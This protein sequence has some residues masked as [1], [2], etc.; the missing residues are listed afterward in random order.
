[1]DV[2]YS[3]HRQS[4]HEKQM[5]VFSIFFLSTITAQLMRKLLQLTKLWF[6]IFFLFAVKIFILHL[7][8]STDSVGMK[9][10]QASFL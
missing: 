9:K 10:N 8:S 2:L 3:Q 6:S 5:F 1:M 4:F 7:Q